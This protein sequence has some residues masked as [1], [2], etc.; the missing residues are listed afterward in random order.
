MREI[1][2]LSENLLVSEEGFCCMELV[3]RDKGTWKFFMIMIDWRK[4]YL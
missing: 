1:S 4:S 3:S 2:W